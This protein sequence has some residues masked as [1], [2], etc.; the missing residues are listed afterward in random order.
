MRRLVRIP[1]AEDPTRETEM[2]G[3]GVGLGGECPGADD[4]VRLV[5]HGGRFEMVEV[6]LAG[7]V[8]GTGI[9]M[10]GIGERDAEHPG[11]LCAVPR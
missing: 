10:V 5:E 7:E 4:Q 6:E 9:E 2:L 8:G 11:Q 3:L 1:Y